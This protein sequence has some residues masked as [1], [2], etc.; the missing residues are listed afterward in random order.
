MA[1]EIA[2]GMAYLADKKFVHR[3]LAARNCMVAEDLTVKVGDF[4]MTRDIY[5]K[6]YYRKDGR[7]LMPV[8]WMAPEAL[9]DGLFTSQGDVWAFG[10]VLWEMATLASQPY[11]GLANQQVLKYVMDGGV[12]ERPQGCPDRL[13]VLMEM[14]WRYNPKHRPSF[15]DL[16][17][18]LLPDVSLVVT[19]FQYFAA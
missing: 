4:G 16:V 8:R 17:E 5:D 9:R 3:D 2:D 15:I 19:S 7:G 18:D 13:Y 14:C 6:D 11:Q 10:V 1:I 12:M